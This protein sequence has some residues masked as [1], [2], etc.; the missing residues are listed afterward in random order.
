MLATTVQIDLCLEGACF[1]NNKKLHFP[2][3]SHKYL[4]KFFINRVRAWL[5]EI[6]RRQAGRSTVVLIQI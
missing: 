2:L 6:T 3:V 1:A 5:P 4:T